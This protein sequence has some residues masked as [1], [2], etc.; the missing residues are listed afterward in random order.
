MNFNYIPV[1]SKLHDLAE[2]SRLLAGHEKALAGI[3][4]KRMDGTVADRAGVAFH[5]VQT[6]GVENEVIR[7]YRSRVQQGKAGPLLLIAHPVHNSLSAAMEILA[8]VQQEK[9]TGRI[10]LLKGREDVQTLAEIEQT[11]RCLSANHKLSED[12]LGRVGESSDWLVASSQRPEVVSKRFGLKVIPLSVVDL[13]AQIA[14]DPAPDA[15]PE[16]AT[17][18]RATATEGVT[19]E[20]FARAVGIYRGLKALIQANRLSAV[21]VRCFDLV[22]GDGTT[23]CLALSRLADEGITAGCE[24]DIPSVVLLR[25]LWHLTGKAGWMANPADV[26]VRKGE[27]LLAHCT[28]PLRLVGEHRLKTHFESGLGIGIDGSFSTGPVTLLRL[29]GANLDRWWGAEGTLFESRHADQLCRTQVGVRIPPPAAGELLET[30][31]GNHLVL[32]PGHVKAL[33]REAF[34]LSGVMPL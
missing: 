13:R 4:G 24:G 22:T 15:G 30:P 18:D 20:G 16:F 31:L 23:G 32:V 8:Q 7:R 5:F 6:G 27:I 28:V 34:E 19:R 1:V 9:G 29:G 11:A 14:R 3:G 26:D 25:W 33:F 10:Y 2:L 12:R 17:W 21:T